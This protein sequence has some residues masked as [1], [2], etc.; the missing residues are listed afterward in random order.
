V[1]VAHEVKKKPFFFPVI[2]KRRKKVTPEAMKKIRRLNHV[3]NN[4]SV[5]YD[6]DEENQKKAALEQ[7]VERLK[8]FG[9][10]HHSLEQRLA[11]GH[12]TPRQKL[13]RLL[14]KAA[15]KRRFEAARDAYHAKHPQVST[16]THSRHISLHIGHFGGHMPHMPHL[17]HMP[18]MP[19]LTA[20]QEE[21]PHGEQHGK[22]QHSHDPHDPHDHSSTTGGVH[23]GHTPDNHGGIGYPAVLGPHDHHHHRHWK[24]ALGAVGLNLQS[25]AAFRFN[26]T[27][28]LTRCEMEKIKK[29]VDRYR[30]WS[31]GAL[32]DLHK[33]EELA[34]LRHT[35]M[36]GLAGSRGAGTGAGAGGGRRAGVGGTG[37][38]GS[39]DASIST[40]TGAGGFGGGGGARMRGISSLTQDE[41]DEDDDDDDISISGMAA[42]QRR[43][44]QQQQQQVAVQSRKHA[45]VRARRQSFP[46]LEN[47]K[48]K[49]AHAYI[50]VL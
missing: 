10:A 33:E 45:E 16:G 41:D 37:L 25:I 34:E 6:S 40:R 48:W 27:R 11:R 20:H 47:E 1:P 31:F 12:E 36:A 21:Q 24:S 26:K 5:L 32:D 14:R 46:S 4:D 18:H 7:M 49:E 39:F 15:R 17:P 30:R 44:Q 19:H 38:R 13:S 29:S 28:F 8:S 22:E 43:K 3:L 35:P 50:G 9:A 42:R 2:T 23:H